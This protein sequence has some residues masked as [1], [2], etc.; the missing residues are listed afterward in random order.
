MLQTQS[1]AHQ[2]KGTQ[3]FHFPD[4]NCNAGETMLILGQSGVGKS[5]LLH[6]LAGILQ[7][8]EGK[9]QINDTS[10]YNLSGSKRD[11]F[12]GKEIG[13][14]FQKPHF[15]QSLNAFDNLILAQKMAGQSPTPQKIKALLAGLNLD[16]RIHAKVHQMSQGELQRLSIA[17]ALVNEPGLLLADEPTSALDDANCTEVIKLMQSHAQKVNAALIIVTHDKRLKDLFP[18]TIEL[19]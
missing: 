11:K 17:R 9:V 7:P 1:I 3:R 13:L 16:Q 2:Y 14:I 12:R 18:K 19:K 6:I 10:L 15:V 4:I 8:K 5:T